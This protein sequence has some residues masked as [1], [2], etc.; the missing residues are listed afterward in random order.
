MRRTI[1][2]DAEQPLYRWLA[3]ERRADDVA[4]ERWLRAL[5]RRLPQPA[6]S[7]LLADRV[8][9]ALTAHRA[10][11]PRPFAW[12]LKLLTAILL[13]LAA[14]A[15]PTVPGALYAAAHLIEPAGLVT[16][17]VEI[18]TA[19]AGSL[20]WAVKAWHLVAEVERALLTTIT[21]PPVALALLTA[22][23]LVAGGLAGLTGLLAPHRSRVHA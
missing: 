2:H 10:V 21:A 22:A 18:L 4:A 23:L 11:G 8:L 6:V 20:Q 19:L 17:S 7:P 9:A 13:L 1:H 5:F 14:L 15:A 12:P 3:A 16:G